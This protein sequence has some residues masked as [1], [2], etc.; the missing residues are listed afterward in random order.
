MGVINWLRGVINQKNSP[1]DRSF[2][3]DTIIPWCWVFAFA[4]SCLNTSRFKSILDVDAVFPLTSFG[5]MI[6]TMG[7]T[8]QTHIPV[9][10]TFSRLRLPCLGCSRFLR[11]LCLAKAASEF[12]LRLP[13]SCC[14][15]DDPWMTH[16]PITW[17]R[18]PSVSKD[19]WD[20]VPLY[21]L[22]PPF[23]LFSASLSP[24]AD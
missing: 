22:S 2:L 8:W 7:L 17:Q 3:E 13:L 21:F 6:D 24:S 23:P 15:F 14:F 4:L 12:R 10:V 18:L 19:W 9:F 1:G 11:A 20:F 5:V 16:R